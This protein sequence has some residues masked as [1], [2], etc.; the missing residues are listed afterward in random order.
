MSS[1]GNRRDAEKE[2]FWRG[3]L[4]EQADN[5]E[6]IRTFCDKRKLSEPQFYRWR[7][8]LKYR[9]G[10]TGGGRRKRSSRAGEKPKPFALVSY[11]SGEGVSRGPGPGCVEVV[12]ENGRRVCVGRGVGAK[13]LGEIVGALSQA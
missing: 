2:R 9:D 6:T 8:E 12:L 11:P 5:R 4:Q 13:E 10:E 7:R 3:V 1:T